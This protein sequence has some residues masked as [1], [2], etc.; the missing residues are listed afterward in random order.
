MSVFSAGHTQ[1]DRDR[2]TAACPC[3]LGAN[4]TAL[5]TLMT[6]GAGF[7]SPARPAALALVIDAVHM[8]HI[9][10]SRLCHHQDNPIPSM[11]Y[12]VAT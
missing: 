4:A 12:K 5:Q 10:H 9:H 1:Q 8:A 2:Q 3:N 11:H 7:Q 6:H